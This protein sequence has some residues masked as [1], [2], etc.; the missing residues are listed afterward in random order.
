MKHLEESK[1]SI[2]IVGF[3]PAGQKC[4]TQLRKLLP[5]AS[6]L[7]Y[8]DESHEPYNRVKLTELF[9]NKEIEEVEITKQLEKDK[10]TKV[11]FGGEVISI[12]AE[13]M[14]I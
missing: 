9:F 4:Y 6:I 8:S 14:S 1:H 10:N 2:I 11:V 13:K 3:G 5:D 7:I 12:D